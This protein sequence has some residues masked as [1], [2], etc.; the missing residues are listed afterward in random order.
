MQQDDI[1]L[2]VVRATIQ[3]LPDTFRTKD[4]SRHEDMT[5]AHSLYQDDKY[6]HSAIGTF[7]SAN[8]VE[9]GIRQQGSSNKDGAQWR[10]MASQARGSGRVQPAAEDLEEP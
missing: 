5:R 1:S 8:Q 4:V 2:A 9:L 6:Y 7:L 10:K 3:K